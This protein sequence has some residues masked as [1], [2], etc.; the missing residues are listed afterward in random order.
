MRWVRRAWPAVPGALLVV[1]GLLAAACAPGGGGVAAP[2]GTE[3]GGSRVEPLVLEPELQA[4]DGRIRIAAIFPTIGRYA[5]SGVQSLNGVRLAVEEVNGGGGVLGR[6]LHLLEYRT[7]SYFVDARRA[8]GLAAEAGVLAFVASNS[9]ELSMA[10]AEEA[11][12]RGVVQVSNISTAQELTWDPVSGEDRRFVFRVCASDVEMG[13]LIAAF[14]RDRLGARRAAVLY[15]VGRTYSARLAQAFADVFRDEAA[16]RTI[17][18]FRYLTLET[19]FRPQLRALARLGPDIV[20]LPASFTDATLVVRQARD[21]GL[22]T[23]FIGGDAWSHPLLFRRGGPQSAAYFVELC[24][25]SPAFDRRYEAAFGVESH[26]CRALLAADALRVVAAGLQSLGRLSDSD[27]GPELSVT[28]R[29]LRDAVAKSSVVGDSGR[30]HFD[31]HGDRRRGVA[32]L[33]V[34]PRP[35]GQDVRIEG[36]LGER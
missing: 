22:R 17:A 6:K 26:G 30:I 9:S 36:W 35:H 31:A 4:P 34:M 29:R 10:V 33:A 18:E 13:A 1:E 24:E 20:F 19:D 28:R 16:G 27:L 12:S 15:E 7:G 5:P 14:A 25:P 21:V 32:L 11:E 2:R 23:T 3:T 8:A